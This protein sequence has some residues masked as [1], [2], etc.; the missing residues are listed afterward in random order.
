MIDMKWPFRRFIRQSIET[1]LSGHV[2][3]E[4]SKEADEFLLLGIPL[5]VHFLANLM[6]IVT[7]QV[8]LIMQTW[9]LHNQVL[10]ANFHVTI[11]ESLIF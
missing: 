2:R 11:V 8:L 1:L 3:L 4:L 5:G 7:V 10:N 6:L 9:S